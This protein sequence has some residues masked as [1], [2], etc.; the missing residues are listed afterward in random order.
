MSKEERYR[1]PDEIQN[2]KWIN[3]NLT[4]LW[5]LTNQPIK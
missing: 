1:Y 5:K 2:E 3:P 4:F